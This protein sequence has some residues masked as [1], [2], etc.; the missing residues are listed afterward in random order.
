MISLFCF[1]ILSR[2]LACVRFRETVRFQAE[3]FNFMKVKGVLQQLNSLYSFSFYTHTV[4]NILKINIFPYN[5]R[6]VSSDVTNSPYLY[7]QTYRP[8]LGNVSKIYEQQNKLFIL[9]Q[10]TFFSFTHKGR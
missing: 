7:D 8:L 3:V 6:C 2:S 10:E 9:H 5:I 4:S 1:I